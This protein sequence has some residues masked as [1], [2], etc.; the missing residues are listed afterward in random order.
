MDGQQLLPLGEGKFLDRMHDLDAGVGDENVHRAERLGGRIDRG[1]DLFLVRYVG[2][3]G[4]RILLAAEFGRRRF[5]ASRLRSAIAT[6]PPAST[7]ACYA[8]ADAARGAVTNATLPLSSIESIPSFR[9]IIVDNLAKSSVKSATI[10]T[11]RQY[12]GSA[13]PRWEPADARRDRASPDPTSA[14]DRDI[15]EPII[16]QFQNARRTVDMRDKLEQ[17]IRP[18]IDLAT[19][20][21]SSASY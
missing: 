15:L 21:R 20:A 18:S 17:I 1:V 12:R 3:H 2:R 9:K 19:V 10:W 8:M 7:N 4:D 14:F 16:D 13:T 11:R 6:R 5:R